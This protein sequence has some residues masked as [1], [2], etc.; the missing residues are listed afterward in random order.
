MYRNVNSH[1]ETDDKSVNHRSREVTDQSCLLQWSHNIKP[2]FFLYF[3]DFYIVVFL[4]FNSGIALLQHKD[5]LVI[6]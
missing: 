2:N 1:L 6:H 4:F 5:V 3:V